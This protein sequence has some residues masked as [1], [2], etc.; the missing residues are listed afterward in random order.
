MGF[1]DFLKTETQQVQNTEFQIKVELLP[2]N[3]EISF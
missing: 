3:D 1:F 2:Q